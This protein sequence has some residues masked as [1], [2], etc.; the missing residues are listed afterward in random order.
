[1]AKTNRT[2][3]S[4]VP[5]PTVEYVVHEMIADQL[6]LEPA[7]ESATL[8]GQFRQ[9]KAMVFG[10]RQQLG[11]TQEKLANLLGISLPSVS[12][13]ERE[14]KMMPMKVAARRAELAQECGDVTP[15]IDP[16][17]LAVFARRTTL[18]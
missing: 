11:V 1:M 18:T 4:H 6:E 2:S 7:E 14:G 13:Y 9:Q 12:R 3:R 16:T 17:A 15:A 5:K 8:I 10:L